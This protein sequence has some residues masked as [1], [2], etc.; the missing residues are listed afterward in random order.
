M[1]TFIV[2]VA[3]IVLC[4]APIASAQEP[5]GI[6]ENH[7]DIGNPEPAG[8]ATYDSQT[9]EYKVTCGGVTT[10]SRDVHI[11][12]S[13]VSGDFSLKA[14][15]RAEDLDGGHEW[16]ASALLEVD[17]DPKKDTV[18]FGA[19]V[20]VNG[21]ATCV[22]QSEVGGEPQWPSPNLP[23]GT[24][25]G[26][27]KLVREGNMVSMYYVDPSTE[28]WTLHYQREM[29]LTDPVYVGLVVSSFQAG[30]TTVGYF[31][32]VELITEEPSAVEDWE[33]YQ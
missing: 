6:F 27:V 11:V 5:V 9:G 1:R 4:L 31:T 8:E 17:D 18:F 33:L 22:W 13:E 21:N 24:H 20:K 3:G 7:M 12:Y 29:D 19:W 26:R 2:I 10:T 30:G 14:K 16:P 32:D 28:E 25:D 23:V 15:I